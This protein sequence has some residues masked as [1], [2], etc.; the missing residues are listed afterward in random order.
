VRALARI[1]RMDLFM[2]H[3]TG[4]VEVGYTYLAYEAF[5]QYGPEAQLGYEIP[6]GTQRAKLKLG[7]QVQQY[8]FSHPSSLLDQATIQMLGIDHNEFLG[9]YKA[10]LVLDFRDHPVEPR[11]GIYGEVQATIGTRAAGG[12]YEYQQFTPE[13]RGYVPLGPVELAARVRYGAIFGDVPPTERF[14]A[15]GASSN[16]G[17]SERELSPGVTGVDTRTNSTITVPYGGA[18][19]LDSSI[20]ARVPLL[21]IK[22]M[23]LHG[24][25]FMDGGDVTNTV[26]ELDPSNLNWAAGLGLRLLTVI[27]PV[28]TDFGYRLNR[29]GPDD[30]EPLSKWAFHLSLGEAF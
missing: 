29:T 22:S 5:T 16:R 4:S 30:P 25:V 13:L 7:Y 9:A 10:S 11:W 26:S 2:T 8:G 20:E 15:G 27:G 1:D 14:Y 12:E 3:A 21:T 28:R 18:A 23:P 6:L 17:F 19:L 24:V